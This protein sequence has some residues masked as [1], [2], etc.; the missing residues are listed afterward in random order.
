MSGDAQHKEEEAGALL[1][2]RCMEPVPSIILQ[3]CAEERDHPSDRSMD[4]LG[5]STMRDLELFVAQ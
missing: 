4:G 2:L 5:R 3:R 1:L